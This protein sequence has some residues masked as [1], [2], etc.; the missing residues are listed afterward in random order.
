MKARGLTRRPVRDSSIAT[1]RITRSERL[2][3]LGL[4]LAPLLGC[5]TVPLSEG[6]KR[7]L[8]MKSDPPP[9][10]REV[11]SVAARGDDEEIKVGMRHAA[12]KKGGNYVRMEAFNPLTSTGTGTA[13]RCANAE[14]PD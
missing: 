7:V 14:S 3:A 9:D 11:G 8:L 6:G 1:A 2:V 4:T 10:C 5:Y 13:F 12:A